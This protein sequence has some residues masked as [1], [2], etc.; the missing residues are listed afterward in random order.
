MFETV[1]KPQPDFEAKIYDMMFQIAEKAMQDRDQLNDLPYL[2]SKAQ[3]AKHIFNV[4]PQTL[5]AHIV[6][7]EDFPKIK[8]GERVLYP[9]DEAVKWIKDHIQLANSVAPE[10]KVGV[11]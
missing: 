11:Y 9:K 2:L 8:I 6:K 1:L 3:L 5:D 4:S 10:R 7:R